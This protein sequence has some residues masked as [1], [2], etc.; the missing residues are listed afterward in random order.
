MV[1]LF[2]WGTSSN[3]KK[4][5]SICLIQVS[6]YEACDRTR[7]PLHT[8]KRLETCKRKHALFDS[9]SFKV[10]GKSHV[11]NKSVFYFS[12]SI[13][14]KDLTRESCVFIFYFIGSVVKIGVPKIRLRIRVRIRAGGNFPRT[15]K[16]VAMFLFSLRKGRQTSKELKR[17]MND[18]AVVFL[19]SSATCGVFKKSC[20]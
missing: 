13:K 15:V 16:I 4:F 2:S 17:N 6:A 11:E 14:H 20:F 5:W 8:R 7:T 1:A 10:C 18:G 19:T 9:K 3:E 12:L